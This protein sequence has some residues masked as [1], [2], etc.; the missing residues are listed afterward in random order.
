MSPEV[1]QMLS[2]D[3][4]GLTPED[5]QRRFI[6]LGMTE[7]WVKDNLDLIE[8]I[9]TMYLKVPT[10]LY[11]FK[12]QALAGARFSSARRLKK[13]NTPTLVMHGKKDILVLPQNAEILA[14]LIPEAKLTYFE[15]SAHASY[16][17]EPKNVAKA[18]FEFLK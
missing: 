13:I 17:E 5:M 16:V 10:P 4:E 15:N 2:E 12:R 14:K 3:L 18:L 8:E 6:P 7:E 9:I 1:M 11:S